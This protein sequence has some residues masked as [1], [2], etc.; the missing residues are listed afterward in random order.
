MSKQSYS[1]IALQQRYLDAICRLADRPVRVMEVCG[2][3]TNALFRYGIEEMLPP[4][5]VMVHGPGCPVCVT[6]EEI[7]SVAIRLALMP[8]VIFCTF[9]DMSRVPS[10]GSSLLQARAEGAD[11]RILY[12]PLDAVKVAVAHPDKQ[13]VFF[14]IG[15]ETTLPLYA[16]LLEQ[17]EACKIANLSLLTALF[18]MPAVL[19]A[20]LAAPDVHVDALLAPGHVCAVQGVSEYAILSR[21]FRLPIVITGF[22]PLEIVSGIY[23]ALEALCR[24]EAGVYNAYSSVVATDGNREARQR[25]SRFFEPADAWWRGLGF[26]KGSGLRLRREY[27]QYDALHRFCI[28]AESSLLSSEACPAGEVM[29][30]GLMPEDCHRFGRECTPEHPIGAPMVSSEGICAARYR[31]RGS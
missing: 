22:R 2:G 27:E 15:F 20:L 13:V 30:G 17:A 8:D 14:A 28:K 25:A 4:T 16:V 1:N 12:S 3:Q 6:P 26:I 24:H 31:N 11:L 29:K 19:N 5:V 7:V 21:R 10:A 9:G 18:T 23:Y